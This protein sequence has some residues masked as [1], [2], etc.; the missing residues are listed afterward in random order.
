MRRVLLLILVTCLCLSMSACSKEEA[1]E[2][3]SLTFQDTSDGTF[4][5]IEGNIKFTVPEGT[6]YTVSQTGAD[7]DIS[8]TVC[9][10]GIGDST[11][12]VSSFSVNGF[13]ETEVEEKLEFWNSVDEKEFADYTRYDDIYMDIMGQ[14]AIFKTYLNEAEENPRL[15]LVSN[16]TDSHYIYLVK[17]DIA[18]IA[19]EYYIPVAEMIT[20]SEYIGPERR[21]EL[22]Q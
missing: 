21:F 4:T 22:F 3:K 5:F 12:S 18:A 17:M 14:E 2:N 19:E 6:F 16:F 13:N 7:S 15:H 9:G 10:F 20:F 11:T 8:V 1:P